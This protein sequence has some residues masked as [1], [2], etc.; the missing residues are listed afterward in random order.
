MEGSIIMIYIIFSI[1]CGALTGNVAY[2]KNWDYGSW[3][4]GGLLFNVIALIAAAGLPMGGSQE[5]PHCLRE[6]H[7][8]ATVCCHC[9]RQLPEKPIDKAGYEKE[10]ET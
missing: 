7:I 2:K 5:C 10:E 9:T 3:F 4:F 8:K 6:I 1:A